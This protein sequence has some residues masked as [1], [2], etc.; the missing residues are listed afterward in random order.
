MQRAGNTHTD[1]M[2]GGEGGSLIDLWRGVCVGGGGG[3]GGGGVGLGRGWVESKKE[4][5]K[6]REESIHRHPS[7]HP[8]LI[9]AG[10]D[11]R[12]PPFPYESHDRGERTILL[13]PGHFD[14]LFFGNLVISVARSFHWRSLRNLSAVNKCGKKYTVKLS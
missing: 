4:G 13:L 10:T 1:T 8:F 2:R 9:C 14:S 5:R 7:I 12:A 6:G 11:T 3:G